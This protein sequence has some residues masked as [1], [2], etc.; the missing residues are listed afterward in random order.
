[1]FVIQCSLDVVYRCVRHAA[2]IQHLQPLFRG[3]GSCL[4]LDQGLQLD[5]VLHTGTVRR[6][7]VIA[8]P[9]RSP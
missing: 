2:L 9:F 6:E 4:C 1:M 7:L 5:S 8:L 3:S